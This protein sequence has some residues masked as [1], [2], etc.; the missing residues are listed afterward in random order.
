MLNS[1]VSVPVGHVMLEPPASSVEET[2]GCGKRGNSSFHA[3]IRQ[4]VLDYC[5]QEFAGT[6]KHLHAVFQLQVQR[7]RGNISKVPNRNQ[8]FVN[9]FTS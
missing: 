6:N 4:N 9:I 5:L 8:F 7:H 3:E 1:L 2:R